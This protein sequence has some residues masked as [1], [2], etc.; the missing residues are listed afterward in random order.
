MDHL[1]AI[2]SIAVHAGQSDM[3][4]G[5]AKP[6]MVR[7]QIGATV[8]LIGESGF[9]PPAIATAIGLVLYFC[10][11]IVGRCCGCG[12]NMQAAVVFLVLSTTTLVVLVLSVLIA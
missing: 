11:A 7:L 10:G 2:T 12:R 8:G 1:F 5:P 4:I 9:G 3:N 6:L